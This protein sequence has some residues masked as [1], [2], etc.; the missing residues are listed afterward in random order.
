MQ[1]SRWQHAV[2]LHL[3]F[4]FSMGWSQFTAPCALTCHNAARRCHVC[5]GVVRP[6]HKCLFHWLGFIITGCCIGIEGFAAGAEDR[7]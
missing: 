5:G 6:G 7:S 3:L 1:P 2:Q 4:T